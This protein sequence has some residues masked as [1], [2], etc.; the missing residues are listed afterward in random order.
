[1]LKPITKPPKLLKLLLMEQFPQF[2]LFKTRSELKL[3]MSTGYNRN[4]YL[5]LTNHWFLQI[6]ASSFKGRKYQVSFSPMAINKSQ[7]QIPQIIGI[8]FWQSCFSHRQ[9]YVMCAWVVSNKDLLKST[10]ENNN[11]YDL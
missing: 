7:M 8:G 1:M 6:T 2:Q 9:H 4:Q 11:N 10:Q 5:I 3:C